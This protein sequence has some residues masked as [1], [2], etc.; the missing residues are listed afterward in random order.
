MTVNA[1]SCYFALYIMTVN[2]SET[3]IMPPHHDQ[4]RRVA[5]VV[6]HGQCVYG[7]E[8]HNPSMDNATVLLKSIP[9]F[10]C[11]ML[12]EPLWKGRLMLR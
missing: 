3:P 12:P 11:R 1:C 8:K 10:F 7:D 4:Y 2:A 6:L 9:S 5:F